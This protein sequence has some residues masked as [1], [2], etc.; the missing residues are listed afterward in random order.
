MFKDLANYTPV[1]AS[2]EDASPTA[3]YS[4]HDVALAL[5]SEDQKRF[6]KKLLK[7]GVSKEIIVR[8]L[9][10]SLCADLV[11]VSV[12]SFSDSDT[13]AV[14]ASIESFNGI[15]FAKE[16]LLDKIKSFFGFKPK[17]TAHP[18]KLYDELYPLFPKL[19]A[20]LDK[21]AKIPFPKETDI[22][23][24]RKAKVLLDKLEDEEDKKA[25]ATSQVYEAEKNSEL[26]SIDQSGWTKASA[27][28][29]K[30]DLVSIHAKIEQ[31][32]KEL[33]PKISKAWDLV[34]SD[35]ADDLDDEVYGF[36]RAY[37]ERVVGEQLWWTMRAYELCAKSA[38]FGLTSKA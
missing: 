11:G 35:T 14:I 34:D 1:V 25:S 7:A 22:A 27:E 33:T 18:K 6:V 9:P 12:E 10:K 19:F 37:A 4:D 24:V 20:S 13:D 2:V 16:N 3:S 38:E 5:E 8:S 23:G 17:A 30:S 21:A 36:F 32:S 26:V 15:A 29:A 31:Y 28:K